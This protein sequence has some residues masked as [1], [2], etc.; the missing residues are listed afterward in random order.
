MENKETYR[1]VC[2]HALLTPYDTRE[3]D[4]KKSYSVAFVRAQIAYFLTTSNVYP[5]STNVFIKY[6]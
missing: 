3:N 4:R 2:P 5:R 1:L 6:C